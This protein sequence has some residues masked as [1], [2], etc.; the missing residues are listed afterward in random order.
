M[1]TQINQVIM[2]SEATASG[3]GTAINVN[4]MSVAILEISGTFT[5][6]IAFEALVKESWVAISATNVATGT[7][8][9][10]AST[11]GAYRLNVAGFTQL[12]AVVTWTSGTSI[13]ILGHTSN[14]GVA[15]SG[16]LNGSI[17]KTDRS[18]TITTGGTS[19]QLMAS[20]ASR[21]G[22]QLQNNSTAAIA[23]NE[24]GSAASLT[25]GS[26]ILQPG[27]AYESPVGA[28]STAQINVI[29]ATTGQ[30]FTAR[31]W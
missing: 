6:S 5:A 15:D 10:T 8:A 16:G 31:E 24:L 7:S 2:H 18:G 3:S 28:V 25:S 14:I 22:W 4:G 23:F 12:R 11:A 21:K 20:N 27:G 1:A 29:G 9:A 19:Q 30:V 17:V 13:T 26:F